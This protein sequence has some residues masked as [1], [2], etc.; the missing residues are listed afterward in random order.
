MKSTITQL[1][2][3]AFLGVLVGGLFSS[4]SLKAQTPCAG[5]NSW[6]C[7]GAL[8]GSGTDFPGDIVSVNVKDKKGNSLAAYSGLNCTGNT[9]ASTYKGIL[10]SG[11]GFDLTAS[12]EISVTVEGGTWATQSWGTRVGIWIDANRDGQYGATECL[13]DPSSNI[14]SGFVTYN[15][16]MPC[17]TTTGLSHM[18][19]RGGASVYTLSSS[20]GCGTANTYGNL[21]DLEVNLKLG[22]TPT[23]NFIVPSSTNYVK[24][25]IKFNAL[26]P[27]S[28]YK[29]KWT[30]DKAV[31]PPYAGYSDNS[32][33]GVAKWASSGKYDVKM[34]VSYCG[35]ADSITKQVTITAPTAAPVAD[36]V[37][38]SNETE[39][40]YDVTMYDLS[41]NGAY[42]WDW[43]LLSP[44]GLDDQTANNQNPKFTLSETGWYKVCLTSANDIG[45]STRVCKDRYIECIAPTEYYMGP[46]KEGTSKNGKLF[47]NGGPNAA[48]G[49]NRKTSI[50]YFKI[51]PCGAEKITLSFGELKLA[52]KG[53]ILRIYDAKEATLGK[54]IA[55]INS[56]NVSKYDTAKIVCTSGAV[57]ITFETNGSGTANGFII[58]WESKLSPPKKPTAQWTTDYNPAA[59]GLNVEFKN[60][61]K[62]VQGLPIYEWQIDQNPE[63]SATD[64]NRAFYTDG[65]YDV[66]L[67]ALTCT[68]VDTFCS[69]VTINTPTAPGYLDY[70]AS[71]VR[72]NLGDV[73]KITTKT[74]YANTFEWSIF[75]TSFTFEN[76][77]SKNSQ[78]PEIKFQKGGAYTFTLSAYNSVG[79]K[80][81]TEKKLIKNKYVIVLDYC[82]P[83]V[84]LM[85]ADVGINN[86]TLKKGS[87][88]L[89]NATSTSGLDMYSNS[90]EDY[91]PAELTFGASYDLSVA[92]N[93]IANN[94][95]YKAWIDFNIDG[96]FNDAGE[97]VMSSGSTSASSVSGSFTVPTLAN[98]FE[99]MTR[100]RVGVS[101]GAFSNTPCGLNTVGEFEDYAIK[102][103]NDNLPPSITLVGADTM[104]V[105]K[106]STKTACYSEVAGVSYKAQDPTQG[107]MTSAVKVVSDLDCTVPGIYTIEFSLED[108]SGNKAVN[109]FRTVVVA[110]D[111]TAP[112]LTLNGN[113]TLI[114][115]QCDTY[116]EAGAVAIDA[117]DGNL[118]SAIKIA[119]KVEAGKVGNY[120]LTYS[121]KDAQANSISITRL[122]V[123]KDTKAPS[124]LKLAKSIVDGTTIDVQIGSVF[125]DDVYSIDP[126]NG[127]IF[128]SKNPGFNGP[129]NTNVRATYPVTYNAVDPSGNKAVE[130]GFVLN[131]RVDDFI[132]PE[133]EL[134]TGDTVIHDVNEAYYS[135]SVTVMDNYYS[136]SQVSLTKVGK[137][138]AYTLGTYVET[139]TATDGS[140]N[141]TTKQRFIKVVDRIA[142]TVT[143][144]PVS[145]C[146]GTPFWA[147][148]GLIVRDNYYSATDL[149]PLVKVLGHN[150]NVMEA[151][152]YYINYSLVDPS[153]NE[154]VTVSR[155]VFVA[156]P[157][158]CFNTYM[159]TENVKLEDAV[160]VYP[161]PTSGIVTVGYNLSN[162]QPLDVTVVNAMGSVVAKL[163]NIQGG[164]GAS[165]IDLTNVSEGIYFVNLTN[166][167]QTVTK[168]IV[169]KH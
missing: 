161:N 104:R 16:K 152:V 100:L 8:V 15:L 26:N 62:D 75:P 87:K 151:G 79:G 137:V 154:A 52:D 98:S 77:T 13:V 29:Y 141:V 43:E 45:P 102:L 147:L 158:N 53:D 143:A 163:D 121:V 55:T 167:G 81:S 142:P 122:V 76:G 85:S 42:S 7:G 80:A 93:T 83:L 144:P 106:A 95:N 134:N 124:I 115:E 11:K 72:P 88:E 67:I 153:G 38:S 30:F 5:A 73:V 103:A 48:Y 109:R 27:S 82:I 36:F 46:S 169:V 140:G 4:N 69:T 168:R 68:G 44:T 162:T 70:T 114:L 3:L 135:R 28:G 117:N 118:T 86:V 150:V 18:R 50:D 136:K 119:G 60:T 155:P 131:Y 101:Y 22:A 156:Y 94:V 128:V 20:N 6:G 33:K 127:S 120:L 59:N 126:C 56:D 64:Y 23:A 39:I 110:L 84:D 89:L 2:K 129:V 58:N 35:L 159:G 96:D 78:N 123:V 132:A 54:L 160:S 32:E 21:L 24:T 149:T 139:F 63:S 10:N 92:R 133:I 91:V 31:A 165:Q 157:P 34:L 107:D 25:N 97:E 1:K 40:Y 57:Y 41:N 130:D 116:N 113:D 37:S 105:E 12:E 47:D 19:I 108:A 65:Q 74:D 112:K 145:V 146:I 9:T 49:N 99:G 166:N 111:K 51:L 66:C 61:S 138:D 125:V 164:F 17:W 90:T 14:A 71:N 148:S